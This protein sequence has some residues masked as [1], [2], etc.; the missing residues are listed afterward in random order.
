VRNAKYWSAN[1]ATF[2]MPTPADDTADDIR[3]HWGGP[4]GVLPQLHD[5]AIRA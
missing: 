3:P 2:V 1:R 5:T 4:G